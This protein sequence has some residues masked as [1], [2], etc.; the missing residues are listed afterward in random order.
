MPCNEITGDMGFTVRSVQIRG[1]WVSQELREKVEQIVG[2]GQPFDPPNVTPAIELVRDEIVSTETT[3]TI[4]LLG[5]TSVLYVDANVCDVSDSLNPRQAEVTIRAY[6]LRIDLYNLGR[7]MLP[8]PRSA[9][10]SFLRE[11]PSTL[12]ATSPVLGF[13]NDRMYGPSVS[14]QTTTDLLQV[15]AIKKSNATKSVQLNLALDLRK[16]LNNPFH[17][18]GINLDILHPV[19]RDTGIGWSIGSQYEN[20]RLSIAK[21]AYEREFFRVYG[22]IQGSLKTAWPVRYVVGA[23]A[24]FLDNQ[25]TLDGASAKSTN[26]DNGYEIFGLI[27]SRILKG[28]GRMGVWFDAGNPRNIPSLEPYQRLSARMGYG[29]VLGAGHQNV[30]LEF[31]LGAGHTWGSPPSYAQYFAGNTRSNFLYEQINSLRNIETPAGPLIRSLGEREGT[32]VLPPGFIQG[33]QSFWHLNANVSFPISSW[34][35]PLIPEIVI[36]EEPRVLTLRSALRGQVASAKNFILDDLITNH[37]YPDTEET[38]A[39]ADRIIEK[40]IRPTI[41]YLAD[42]ANIYSIKPILLFDIAQLNGRSLEDKTW[43][44]LGAG[45]Q[46]TI[47]VARLEVGYMH[48][49]APSSDT[50]IGNL[51]MR[52]TVQ[53]FY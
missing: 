40:D 47:V 22:S 37:G 15:P 13:S 29:R 20:S 7:N 26:R 1:R 16:S 39:V 46:I 32:L 5:S 30:D 38:E 42:R 41:N 25:Y 8:V 28:F 53:N 27:D 6:Y 34:S 36:S 4:R 12:L 45:L 17:T 43:I 19:Y 10:P 44:A 23:S 2:V 24:K 50:D 49:L 9:K 51:F 31:N 3:F 52:F 14:L 48:T 18:I 33:G 21:G 11:V 35:R